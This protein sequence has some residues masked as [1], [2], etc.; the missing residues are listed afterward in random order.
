MKHTLAVGTLLLLG[1][2]LPAYAV[3]G[4]DTEAH[5][6]GPPPLTG[7]YYLSGVREVGAELSLKANGRFSFG[8][9]YGGVD[10]SAEGRWS[11]H[12][13]TL[14]LTSDVPPPP[15]FSLG[16]LGE[17]LI[18][19]YGDDSDKPAL[20]VVKVASPRIGLVWSNMVVSAEFSNGQTRSGTTGRSGTLG[21]LART[22]E[23]WRGAVVRRVSVAYPP[24]EVAPVWFKVDPAKTRSVIVH[25]EPGSMVPPAFETM[26]MQVHAKS[27]GATT[28]L[29]KSADGAGRAGWTFR[30]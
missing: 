23:A 28:L 22:D 12:G 10:R 30:K 27:S 17:S 15:S 16:E 24:G 26:T 19:D 29:Q 2:L 5:M 25:F 9:A 20:I 8:M 18:G 6:E 21:F 7:T 11:V 4:S 14:T 1:L 3:G 13:D